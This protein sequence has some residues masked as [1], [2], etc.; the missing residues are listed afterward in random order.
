METGRHNAHTDFP[1]FAHFFSNL[2]GYHAG[3]DPVYMQGHSVP[4]W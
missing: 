3:V 4:G 1:T 2:P